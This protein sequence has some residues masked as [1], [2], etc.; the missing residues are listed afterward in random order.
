M[1]QKV[2]ITLTVEANLLYDM[3]NPIQE[4]VD[5]KS[6][7]KD[8]NLGCAPGGK[9]K[10][11]QSSVFIN[12]DVMWEGKTN[13][14]DGLDKGL[15]VNIESIVMKGGTNIFG[16]DPLLGSGGRV[17]AKVINDS[18]L[19]RQIYEY[20]IKFRINKPDCDPKFFTID[21]KLMCNT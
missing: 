7:L 13:D 10:D 5:K 4:E 2:T 9:I 8:D 14:P 20:K 6:R 1:G 11:F 19:N 3:T 21:P 17:V 15:S 12:N 16:I 18:K